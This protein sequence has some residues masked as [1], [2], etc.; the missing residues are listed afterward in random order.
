M[1]AD[2]SSWAGELLRWVGREEV[3]LSGGCYAG[4]QVPAIIGAAGSPI[5]LGSKERAP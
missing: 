5:A 2:V 4:H 3:H 1:R